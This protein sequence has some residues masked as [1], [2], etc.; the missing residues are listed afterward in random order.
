ME[1]ALNK[2]KRKHPELAE[3]LQRKQ[4]VLS[5]VKNS[6]LADDPSY[7][8]LQKR[9]LPVYEGIPMG[10]ESH[11]DGVMHEFLSPGYLQPG[12]RRAYHSFKRPELTSV[13]FFSFANNPETDLEHLISAKSASSSGIL[14]YG[15]RKREDLP[16]V[17]EN[18]FIPVCEPARVMLGEDLNHVAHTEQY[19]RHAENLLEYTAFVRYL[20]TG[21]TLVPKHKRPQGLGHTLDDEA[22]S[23][24][25][26]MQLVDDL[27][28]SDRHA[29]FVSYTMFLETSYHA[30]SLVLEKL[31]TGK[32]Q[33][34][35]IDSYFMTGQEHD[36][37]HSS[38]LIELLSTLSIVNQNIKNKIHGIEVI[39]ISY[40][41][42]NIATLHKQ[43]CKQY[44]DHHQ[45]Y[46]TSS[47]DWGICTYGPLLTLYAYYLQ[48]KAHPEN[49]QPDL[50]ELF[51][52]DVFQR[53]YP[54]ETDYE[55]FAID[56]ANLFV[57]PITNIVYRNRRRRKTR[58][59]S[60][61]NRNNRVHGKR[62]RKVRTGPRGGKYVIKNQK[63]VYLKS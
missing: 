25:I 37:L 45:C 20:A 11:K 15:K 5:T 13:D 54:G 8:R 7:I 10:V 31:A 51:K 56:A 18:K 42:A 50:V 53:F 44:R 39:P 59:S 38:R 57:K 1:L 48:L 36:M 49:R 6:R 52:S 61:N 3:R 40:T 30:Q 47:S 43:I 27:L 24:R 19:Q 41:S 55:V 12:R 60:T 33:V 23:I 46:Q 4:D 21:K 34:I 14:T 17:N 2:L 58:K 22:D 32:V 62:L 16:K 28:A 63:K 26:L 29:T 35:L 9:G